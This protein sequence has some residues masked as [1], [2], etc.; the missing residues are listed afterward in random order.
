M[1]SEITACRDVGG[2]VKRSTLRTSCLNLVDKQVQGTISI[3][4]EWFLSVLLEPVPLR[5][6]QHM[7]FMHHLIFFGEQW[8]LRRGPVSW[9][10][11]SPDLNPLHFWLW[12]HVNTLMY[13]ELIYNFCQEIRVKPGIFDSMRTSA[14]WRA[15]SCVEMH[16]NHTEHAL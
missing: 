9:P 12:K 6:S 8:L 15:E 7:W 4:G 10:T 14:L 5:Q 13:S 16:G 2:H 3:F 11:R 1:C